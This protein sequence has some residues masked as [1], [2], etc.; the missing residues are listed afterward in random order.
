[1][2]LGEI[3]SQN[4]RSHTL[5][6]ASAIG[7]LFAWLTSFTAPY[8][9]NPS[10]L[11]WGPRYGYIWFPSCVLAIAWIFWF[12]P[13]MQNR[14]LEEI[15]EMA[16]IFKIIHATPSV[17]YEADIPRSSKRGSLQ[18]N[19]VTMSVIDS[20]LKSNIKSTAWKRTDLRAENHQ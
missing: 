17:V 5:G 6:F 10:A 2:T 9:I 13:E 16:S 1:M 15:T 7:Y 12:L 3:P 14:G 11:N 18:E 4:L 19:S 8:F 20:Q